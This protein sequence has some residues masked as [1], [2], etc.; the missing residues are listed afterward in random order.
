MYAECIV[1]MLFNAC[2]LSCRL[3][4]INVHK[5]NT[6]RSMQCSCGREIRTYVYNVNDM[7][8]YVTYHPYS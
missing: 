7:Y 3:P 8:M 6:D 2:V 5:D 1:H 4:D